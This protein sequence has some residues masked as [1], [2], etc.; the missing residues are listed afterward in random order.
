MRNLIG[1]KP[2]DVLVM[3]KLLASPSLSQK[4]LADQ[5]Y[6]SQAEISHGLKRLKTSNLLNPEGNVIN[7]SC[8]EFLVHAVKYI[9]PAQFGAPSLGIPTS[10]AHPNFKFVRYDPSQ[11]YVWPYAEGKVR[12][13]VLIP[14]YS[15]L[16]QACLIDENLYKIASLV[17][18]IRSGRAREQQIGSEELEK[19]VKKVNAK[20]R[21]SS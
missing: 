9:Y 11:I 12:G 17:E 14:I 13:I 15:T 4:E 21:Y 3:M 1:I 19:I 18:M 5:L 10:Y 6:I 7:Q 20:K 2:Q 8:L 16:P